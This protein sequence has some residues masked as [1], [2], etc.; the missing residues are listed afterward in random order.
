MTAYMTNATARAALDAIVDRCDLGSANAN[1]KLRVYSGTAPADADTALSGN[2]LLAELDMSNPAFGA[3][4]DNSPGAIATASAITDD[5]SAD[6]NGIAT[7]FR[8]VD[9]DENVVLQ[10]TVATSS[11][12]LIVPTT[13]FV[14]GQPVEVSALTVTHAESA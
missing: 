3:A 8:I 5:S 12:N 2:T 13:T 9:R 11:A 14:A 4:A 6:A 1:A 7:F 10:G